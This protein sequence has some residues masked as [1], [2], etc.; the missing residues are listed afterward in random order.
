MGVFIR[1]WF[2]RRWQSA[3]EP[4]WGNE[5]KEC[6]AK[7]LLTVHMAPVSPR[8]KLEIWR[9]DMTIIDLRCHRPWAETIERYVG[10][11]EK[12]NY[13]WR[14]SVFTC[15][16][17]GMATGSTG[18]LCEV[19][20]NNWR[21]GMVTTNKGSP[22]P[23]MEYRPLGFAESEWLRAF[24]QVNAGMNQCAWSWCWHK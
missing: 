12:Y 20:M 15:R 21:G 18:N 19:E 5:S 4:R 2:H 17:N 24:R 11:Q 22:I 6:W 7:L 23:R 10:I 13:T 3:I 14:L 16:D 1:S 8:L 9:D